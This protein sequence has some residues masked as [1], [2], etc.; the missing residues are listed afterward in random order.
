MVHFSGKKRKPL[1]L[2]IFPF[3]SY[4]FH[5]EGIPLDIDMVIANGV[6]GY[7]ASAYSEYCDSIFVMPPLNI[8]VALEHTAN[9]SLTVRGKSYM[10]FLEDMLLTFATKG[11][12]SLY[13]SYEKAVNIIVLLNSHGG[14][15]P[16]LSSLEYF[17][18]IEGPTLHNIH[19]NIKALLIHVYDHKYVSIL[20]KKR[21]IETDTHSGNLE[22]SL[23]CFLKDEDPERYKISN[24]TAKTSRKTFP[25]L[26]RFFPLHHLNSTGMLLSNDSVIIEEKLAEEFLGILK[27]KAWE[28][29][30]LL[31]ER[32]KFYW[33]AH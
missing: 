15:F 17:I 14:N 5:G 16:F 24:A 12:P 28:E 29:I 4:E 11:I 9:F 1:V 32:I 25:Q 27:E 26:L 30:I 20:E 2:Y 7:L 33:K 18:N 19:K 10:V 3:G 13:S 31:Y 21:N 6:A 23:Y 22:L 8:G